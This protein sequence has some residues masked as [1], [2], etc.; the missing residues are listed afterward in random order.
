MKNVYSSLSFWFEL[1]SNLLE[2][3]LTSKPHT[4]DKFHNESK[5]YM[6]DKGYYL[7]HKYHN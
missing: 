3:D 6:S 2:D 1:N 5:H 4:G 7:A